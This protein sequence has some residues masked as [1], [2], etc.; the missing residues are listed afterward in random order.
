VKRKYT[1][2][3]LCFGFTWNA[4]TD[5]PLPVYIVC[6]EKLKNE[7]MVPGKLK[8]HLTTRHPG[9]SLKTRLYFERLLNSNKRAAS[10]MI[11]RVTISDKALEASFKNAELIV[12]NM[13][14]HVIGKELIG[15]AC[16]AMVE[17]MLGK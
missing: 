15:P 2:G 8:R 4:D 3:Y 10:S 14:Y 1:D 11:K 16:L 7:A 12:K 6:G 9:E 17:T 13:N 5:C